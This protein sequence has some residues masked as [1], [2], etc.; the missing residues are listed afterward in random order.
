MLKKLLLLITLPAYANNLPPHIIDH[1]LPGCPTNSECNSKQGRLFLSWNKKLQS[2]KPL[3]KVKNQMGIPL[4]AWAMKERSPNY[5]H[6]DSECSKIRKNKIY[7]AQVFVK[8]LKNSKGQEFYFPKTYLSSGKS[9][10]IPRGETPIAMKGDLLHFNI[11]SEGN[12][13]SMQLSSDGQINFDHP[14]PPKNFP[15]TISCP[16]ILTEE[17]EKNFAFNNIYTGVFCKAIW[18]IKSK[19]YISAIFGKTC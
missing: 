15:Q 16:K 14:S 4:K 2:K 8:K 7:P 11:E 19:S 18:D 13:F 12:Y 9:F 1:K 3:M 6:W 5:I 10:L 17:F